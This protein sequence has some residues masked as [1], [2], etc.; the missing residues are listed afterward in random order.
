MI[1]IICSIV[2]GIISLFLLF[3]LKQSQKS[4]DYFSRELDQHILEVETIYAQMRGIRHDYRN[5][6][7]I[8]KTHLYLNQIEDLK[9]YLNQM[10]HELNQVDT[11]VLSGN[12][13]IDAVINSKLT[14][15]KNQ[16]INLSAKAIVPSEIP[17]SQ[18]DMG[19]L[20]G[21]LLSNAYEAALKSTNPFIRLYLAP[22]KGNLY[23]ICTNSMKGKL[24]SYATTKSSLEH[25]FGLS[26][27][28]QIV[29]KYGG[30][31]SR[32]FEEGVFSTE[33]NLPLTIK[34]EPLVNK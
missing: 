8:L 34:N 7:Q 25:G 19:I 11:I 28:D 4:A 18:L 17:F 15:A 23:L 1:W 29:D 31:I 21:N 32:S 14:L 27:I 24:S 6:L 2:L 22:I 33:I 3:K 20:I 9:D 13:A 26:R 30:M 12:V 10:E 16:G 5:Q